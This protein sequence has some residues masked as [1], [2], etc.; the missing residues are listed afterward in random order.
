MRQ[1][2][3]TAVVPVRWIDQDALGHVNNARYFTY[4][5]NA[6][7]DWLAT[8]V[9]ARTPGIGPVLANTKCEYKRPITYPATLRIS[10]YADPPRR[11][12]LQTYYEVRV[13]GDEDTVYAYG[14][15]LVVW[16]DIKRGRPVS[17]PEPIRERLPGE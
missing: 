8:V 4:F 10:V 17:I 5:E 3:H 16:V 11:S 2:L 14:E 6:R 13:E 9:R 15:A 7:I 1:H 12:S